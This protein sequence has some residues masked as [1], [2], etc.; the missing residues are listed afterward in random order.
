[1]KM[2]T[3]IK[4]TLIALTSA[5]LIFAASCGEPEENTPAKVCELAKL[6][7]DSTIKASTPISQE[8]NL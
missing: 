4:A 8:I 6:A 3:H 7:K 5:L 2:R 1:M